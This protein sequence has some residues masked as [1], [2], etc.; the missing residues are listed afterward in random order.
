MQ[1]F[2]TTT[3]EHRHSNT[4]EALDHSLRVVTIGGGTGH[5]R[6]LRGL[7]RYT[8]QITAVVTVTDNGGSSGK[9]VSDFGI[10]PPGDIRNCLAALANDRRMSELFEFR[11][12]GETSSLAGHP[13]G[14]LILT[15]LFTMNGDDLTQATAHAAEILGACGRVLPSTRDHVVLRALMADGSIV[16]G[17]TQIVLSPAAISRMSISPRA[18][19]PTPQV[20]DAIEDAE[21]IVIGPGSL[22]TSLLPN[23]LIPGIQEALH[24]AR[25]TKVYVCNLATERGETDQFSAADHV[26]AIQEHVQSSL[27]QHVL[28]SSGPAGQL[29]DVACVGADPVSPD[30]HRIRAMGFM[31]SVQTL[32]LQPDDIR[33]DPDLLARAVL[34]LAQ[35][36]ASEQSGKFRTS[37]RQLLQATA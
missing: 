9:L 4:V 24:R 18:P 10:Q 11:F 26:L 8:C 7:K 31:P 3:H 15:A 37:T 27:F 23:L 22:F 32:T 1:V 28:I 17:E 21:L 5:A 12:P 14:N 25:A 36:V 20:I 33:H 13:I 19:A 16:Q 30:V 35:P 6:L 34:E 2:A 29:R